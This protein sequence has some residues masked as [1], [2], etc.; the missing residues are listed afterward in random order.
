LVYQ[1]ISDVFAAASL[2][3]RQLFDCPEVHCTLLALLVVILF[4][5]EVNQHLDRLFDVINQ[6]ESVNIFPQELE[7]LLTKQIIVVVHN[8][9][10]LP[11]L[12]AQ[13]E[14]NE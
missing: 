5:L 13:V 1:L 3:L 8:V 2:T 12:H 9:C 11:D 6:S 10:S 7:S 4:I 14:V